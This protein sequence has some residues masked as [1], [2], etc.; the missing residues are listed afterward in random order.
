MTVLPH[1]DAG[2]SQYSAGFLFDFCGI[3]Y[4]HL[5]WGS[6]SNES[7]FVYDKIIHGN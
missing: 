2:V 7:S 1:S 3:W 5:F 6:F 4:K